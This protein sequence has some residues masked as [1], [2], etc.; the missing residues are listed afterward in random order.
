VSVFSR[1]PTENLKKKRAGEAIGHFFWD[2]FDSRPGLIDLI[3]FTMVPQD[4]NG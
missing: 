1:S 3:Q 2:S 4:L